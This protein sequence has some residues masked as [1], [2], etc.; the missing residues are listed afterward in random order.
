MISFVRISVVLLLLFAIPLPVNSSG[1]NPFG[2]NLHDLQGKTVSIKPGSGHQATAFVFLMADCPACQT[3][4]LTLNN[5]DKKYKAAGIRFIGVVPGNYS[6]PA[7]I[8]EFMHTYK[9]SFPVFTDPTNALVKCLHATIVPEVFLVGS[10][11]Q[12]LYSGRIDDWMAALGKKKPAIHTHDLQ[13][14]IAAVVNHQPVKV[15]HTKAIGCFIEI[16]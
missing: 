13:D 10:E 15:K 3:Y 8:A 4:S 14:A 11:G 5:L 7:E 9:I 16:D 2:I 1:C 12:T 6:T